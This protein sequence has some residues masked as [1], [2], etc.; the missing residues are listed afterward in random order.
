[1]LVVAAC[2]GVAAG[3]LL[4]AATGFG[5]SLV[6]APL[7]FAAIGPEPAVVAL[8]L[9][10]LEV[11]VLTLATEHRRPRPLVPATAAMLAYAVPGAL[12]GVV[13]LR[14]LP[15]GALQVAVSL[16]VAGTLAARHVRRAHIPAWAAGFAAG[17]LTTSTS[18]N[19]PPILLHLLGRGVPASVVRDTLTACFIGL[20]AI[21]GAALF[22]TG[23]PELPDASLIVALIPA[24]A[25][26]HLVGR[27]LFGRLSASGVYEP[28]LTGVLIL[29]VA[30]GLTG[31]LL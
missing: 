12:L 27:R 31:A 7:L 13:I 15:A 10:G 17:A 8:L 5:F 20:T 2:A 29:S 3:A 16:G 19:G 21:G 22:A 24:I 4:Q 25:V 26:A 30:A 6:A 18:I 14:S 11:N 9:L 1:M 23:D 28:V